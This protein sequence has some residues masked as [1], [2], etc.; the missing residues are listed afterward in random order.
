MH[1]FLASITACVRACVRARAHHVSVCGLRPT[2]E[3]IDD[4][5][6]SLQHLQRYATRRHASPVIT[7]SS[8]LMQHT[9]AVYTYSPHQGRQVQ[10]VSWTKL[11][12]HAAKQLRNTSPTS[13]AE[14]LGTP[15][16]SS[17]INAHAVALRKVGERAG[18]SA[19]ERDLPCL[20]RKNNEIF[21]LR[22]LDERKVCNECNCDVKCELDVSAMSS[23]SWMQALQA[24]AV[25]W[26][27]HST[28]R[29][30]KAELIWS[31]YSTDRS[32]I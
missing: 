20:Q 26:C 31:L 8:K 4:H 24:P 15:P 11:C 32:D 7:F 25:A 2:T 17:S 12:E 10:V 9:S 3:Q 27:S 30:K 29:R 23:V 16:T 1:T 13:D 5:R 6:S 21:I 28:I 18:C 19:H 14:P 22:C